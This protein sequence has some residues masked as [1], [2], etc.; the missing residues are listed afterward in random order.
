[1]ADATAHCYTKP[2]GRAPVNVARIE[3][4]PDKLFFVK[5]FRAFGRDFPWRKR[6]T[7]PYKILVTEMLLRQTRASNVRSIWDSFLEHYPN[8]RVLSSAKRGRLVK[9]L[10]VL[11]FGNQRAEALVLAS[12]WIIQ[13]HNGKVPSSLDQLLKI[14]HIGEYSARAILCFAHGKKFEIVDSNVLRF[15]SRYY[16]LNLNADNRRNRIAWQIARETLPRTGKL[17]KEHNYG[18]LDFTAE[19]CKSEKPVC[20]KCPL[21]KR[22]KWVLKQVQTPGA[23]ANSRQVPVP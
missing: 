23:A 8:V 3:S 20:E 21:A 1:M 15:F 17:A 4:H 22:C 19:I 14:P 12:S 11:G 10:R 16:G 18:L 6:G 7:S 9:Q 5:W 13:N 2:V